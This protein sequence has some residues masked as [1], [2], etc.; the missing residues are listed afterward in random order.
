[1]KSF[2][3]YPGPER[4]PRGPWAHMGREEKKREHFR[5]ELNGKERERS[6][7]RGVFVRHQKPAS[8]AS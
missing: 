4:L 3:L 1:M 7:A 8:R 6:N 2:L 5:K